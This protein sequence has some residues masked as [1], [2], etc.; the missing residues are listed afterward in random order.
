MKFEWTGRAQCSKCGITFSD[1]E[2]ELIVRTEL[3]RDYI[4]CPSCLELIPVI[5]TGDVMA[6]EPIRIKSYHIDRK[7]VLEE[8]SSSGDEG[9]KRA[10]YI[11]H[12]IR[13]MRVKMGLDPSSF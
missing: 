4:I 9:K 2:P 6:K 1:V 13:V 8:I 5:N 10:K 7:K 3:E 11:M 12:S